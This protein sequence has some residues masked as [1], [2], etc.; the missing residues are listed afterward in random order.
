MCTCVG[1]CAACVLCVCCA[2]DQGYLP[3]KTQ[4]SVSHPSALFVQLQQPAAEL[5][6]QQLNPE[7]CNSQR[8]ESCLCDGPTSSGNK[9]LL[10]PV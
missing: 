2:G 5:D 10:L 4:L 9:W 8:A 1:V 7:L 3:T 6:D